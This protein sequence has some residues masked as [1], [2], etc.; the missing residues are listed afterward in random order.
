MQCSGC[1]TAW[2]CSTGESLSEL[3]VYIADRTPRGDLA[4]G[5]AAVD[6]VLSYLY[7]QIVKERLVTSRGW[8][9]ILSAAY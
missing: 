6:S 8:F 7:L 2:Y 5:P 9:Y 4:A 3:D 1:Q